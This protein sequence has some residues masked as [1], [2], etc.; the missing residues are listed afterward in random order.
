MNPDFVEMLAALPDT[1]AD[2]V[3]RPRDLADV[4]DTEARPEGDE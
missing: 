1:E 4:T 3:G 2:L